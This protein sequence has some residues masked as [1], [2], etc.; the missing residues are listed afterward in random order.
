MKPSSSLDFNLAVDYTKRDERCCGAVQIKNG[1][2]AAIVLALAPGG[3]AN[4]IDPDGFR[5]YSNRSFQKTIIDQGAALEANWRTGLLGDAKLTS[6]T[7]IRNWSQ[8]G[9]ADVDWTVGRHPVLADEERGLQPGLDQ[10]PHLQP[11]IA[12][13]RLDRQAELAGR[14]VLHP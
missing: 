5:D 11:G 4:P 13:G 6:V 7:A 1:A 10:V 8:V 2:T 14:R 12:A 3:L 9:G